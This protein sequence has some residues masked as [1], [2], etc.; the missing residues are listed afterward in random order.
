MAFRVSAP[1]DST[2]QQRA[3][4]T[5]GK[6]AVNQFSRIHQRE[7]PRSTR[8]T[9][10]LAPFDHTG[11]LRGTDEMYS[12]KPAQLSSRRPQGS[13]KIASRN[14]ATERP[15]VEVASLATHPCPRPQELAGSRAQEG[16]GH[17]TLEQ[18]ALLA[19]SAGVSGRK[20]RGRNLSAAEHPA[21]PAALLLAPS[22]QTPPSRL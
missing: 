22:K 2:P 15:S 18:R 14:P 11:S 7:T 20:G 5:G 10:S 9:P 17:R 3:G 19:A 13:S 21:S 8:Y 12:L 4:F 16:W 1:N 6:P